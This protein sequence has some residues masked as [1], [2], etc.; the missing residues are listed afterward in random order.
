MKPSNNNKKLREITEFFY[1]KI[2][3]IFVI[4]LTG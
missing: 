3:V 2:V 1:T 4:K